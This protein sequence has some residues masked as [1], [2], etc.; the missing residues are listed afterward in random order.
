[1]KCQEDLSAQQLRFHLVSCLRFC[2]V[3]VI[4][5]TFFKNS[6]QQPCWL[7][8]VQRDMMMTWIISN[9]VEKILRCISTQPSHRSNKP[10]TT[11]SWTH[12]HKITQQ[13][14]ISWKR[15]SKLLSSSPDKKSPFFSAIHELFALRAYR[16]SPLLINQI[17]LT[18]F[19]GGLKRPSPC[20]ELMKVK[21][22]TVEK[23]ITLVTELDWSIAL[24]RTN[25]TG[26]ASQSNFTIKQINSKP[27]QFNTN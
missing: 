21:P 25:N 3:P 7:A 8:H 23:V 18:S 12:C 13:T 2:T 6:T 27:P 11:Y 26:S 4:S 19:V 14:S 16:A 24:E 5:K 1:M 22:R 9:S 17:H 20:W 15:V 10:F